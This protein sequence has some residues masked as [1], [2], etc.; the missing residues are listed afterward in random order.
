MLLILWAITACTPTVSNKAQNLLDS[1]ISHYSNGQ[2]ATAKLLL[3]SIHS[4]YPKQ[5]EVRKQA[6]HVMHLIEQQEL[7]RNIAYSDSLLPLLQASWDSMAQNFVLLDTLLQPNKT[8]QHKTFYRQSPATGLYC[9]VDKQGN[10]LLVSIYTG[11][12]LDH[13]HL[14]VQAQEVYAQTDTVATSHVNNHRFSD[15]GVRWEYVTFAPNKHGDV[16][17]FISMYAN[18]NLKVTLF[19]KRPYT[20][21]LPQQTAHAMAQSVKFAQQ[22]AFLYQFK[23]AYKQSSDKLLWLEQ[24]IAASDSLLLP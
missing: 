13:T 11:S 15:L 21:Y 14:K 22:T 24:K 1:A 10:L 8:Y 5:V 17:H 3:D 23:Q 20:Y 2:F 9:E 16:P 4:Q 12:V 7:K 18:N 19:G 6:L